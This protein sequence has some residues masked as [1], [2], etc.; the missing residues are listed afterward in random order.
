MLTL[1]CLG[2][3][4]CFASGAFS[5]G[6]TAKPPVRSKPT[7]LPC[8]PERSCNAEERIRQGCQ[9]RSEPRSDQRIIRAHAV[10]GEE[11]SQLRKVLERRAWIIRI[12]FCERRI[13]SG[14]YA[15][16]TANKCGCRGIFLLPG[17]FSLKIENHFQKNSQKS[18]RA[19]SQFAISPVDAVL[20][21]SRRPLLANK[22]RA[23]PQCLAFPDW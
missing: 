2:A 18:V 12:L 17:I 5:L 14:T 22:R 20:L 1:R 23:S 8:R 16:G 10:C 3:L 11:S 13:G 7:A 6:T 9:D 4:A 15:W 21:R 19:R